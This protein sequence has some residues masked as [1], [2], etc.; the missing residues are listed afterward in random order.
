MLHTLNTHPGPGWAITTPEGVILAPCAS[1]QAAEDCL[2]SGDFPE[3]AEKA[4]IS[5]PLG[6]DL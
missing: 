5:D 6:A 4:Y 1:E 2:H 3:T